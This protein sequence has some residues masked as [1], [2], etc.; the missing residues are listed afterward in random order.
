MFKLLIAALL[1]MPVATLAQAP[2]PPTGFS[3]TLVSFGDDS[4]TLKDKD[5]KTVVLQ[6]MPGWTVSVARVGMPG[7]SSRGTLCGPRT[8][9]WM[10]SPASRR[11]CAFWSRGTGRRKALTEWAAPT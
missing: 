10:T 3:G 11:S 1:A 4:V 8:R 6:M 2:P 7:R 9:L 5:G